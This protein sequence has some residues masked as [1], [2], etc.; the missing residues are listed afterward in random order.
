M[1][2]K[3]DIPSIVGIIW[4]TW[5]VVDIFSDVGTFREPYVWTYWSAIKAIIML[6]AI[7]AVGRLIKFQRIKKQ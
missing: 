2:I 6:F 4:F 1:N 7:V 3:T 5:I